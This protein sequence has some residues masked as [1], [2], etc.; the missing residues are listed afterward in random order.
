[1]FHQLAL[2]C[3]HR[4]SVWPGNQ[5]AGVLC[6]TGACL[7]QT[8]ELNGGEQPR[9]TVRQALTA[10]PVPLQHQ[11]NA[12]A[13]RGG[14]HACTHVLCSPTRH[15]FVTCVGKHR[16]IHCTLFARLAE[17]RSASAIQPMAA[18]VLLCNVCSH[19]CAK[20]TMRVSGLAGATHCFVVW[21]TKARRLKRPLTL[22]LLF[23]RSRAAVSA[24]GIVNASLEAPTTQ[25]TVCS[26]RA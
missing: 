16:Q 9:R 1:M 3:P 5:A 22:Q 25:G 7:L 11:T 12:S 13:P 24:R 18:G 8:K 23:V 6:H 14:L 20:Y 21:F 17:A 19:P 10:T 2:E 4:N 15:V 26:N